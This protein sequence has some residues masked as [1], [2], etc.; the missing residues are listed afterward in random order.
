MKI[1]IIPLKK[2]YELFLELYPPQ[3]SNKFI[4]D[5]YKKEKLSN[6]QNHFEYMHNSN[7]N[8]QSIKNCPVVRDTIMEGVTIPLWGNF[9][10]HSKKHEGVIQEQHWDFSARH[11]AGETVDD[12]INFYD[13]LQ[14]KNAPINTMVH[15]MLIKMKIPYKI[16]VP[17]GYNIYYTDPFW[18]LRNEIRILSGIIEADKWG[19]ITIPME[20]L[21]DNF[22]LKAGTPFVQCFIYKRNVSKL[23][24]VTRKG[25]DKEYTNN[26]LDIK[27]LLVSENNYKNL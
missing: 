6:Q 27:K 24:L 12:F 9:K 8:P 13:K 15:N 18:H 25:T 1:E 14:F 19:H 2:E 26:S 7:D 5:W 17:K 23:K 20:I 11:A 4:P 10:F 16:I 3:I 21:K 22:Y